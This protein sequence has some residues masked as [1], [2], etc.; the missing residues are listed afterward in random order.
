MNE[1]PRLRTSGTP[2]GKSGKANGT[3]L[4]IACRNHNMHIGFYILSLEPH[5]KWML[6]AT[7]LVNGIENLHCIL[8]FLYGSSWLTLQ[9]PPGTF[10]C[11]LNIDDHW[12]A[13]G[14]NVLG[15]E[16][17][18]GFTAIADSYKKLPEFITLVHCNCMPLDASIL[19]K[20]GEEGK[21]RK[22]IQTSDIFIRCYC[23]QDTIGMRGLAVV[24]TLMLWQAMVSHI[25]FKNPK[26]VINIISIH[27]TTKLVSFKKFSGAGKFNINLV[28][29]SFMGI[30]EKITGAIS[31]Q[32]T[33]VGKTRPF[34]PCWLL[35]HLISRA[36]IV[37]PALTD[38]EMSLSKQVWKLHSWVADMAQP[39]QMLLRTVIVQFGKAFTGKTNIIPLSADGKSMTYDQN[40]AVL[41]FGTPKPA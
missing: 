2:M 23:Y 36:H 24:C 11:T 19:P 27:V 34:G 16:H 15:T 20:I 22:A 1:A 30:R 38:V 39:N 12:V 25:L 35:I 14:Y 33:T 4:N 26:P 9:L 3:M 32:I 13:D 18:A 6:T 7:P 17:A 21:L 8:Y 5:Y 40:K 31:A 29:G 41:S 10:N 37:G 28:H